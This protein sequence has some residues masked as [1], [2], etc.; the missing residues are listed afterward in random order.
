MVERRTHIVRGVVGAAVGLSVLAVVV[1]AVDA[2]KVLAA[3]AS[4]NWTWLAVA[5]LATLIHYALVGERFTAFMRLFTTDVPD[6]VLRRTGM[7][8]S[9]LGRAIGLAGIVAFSIELGAVKRFGGRVRDLVGASLVNS[10]MKVAI[11]G[12]AAVVGLAW[13]FGIPT[14]QPGA[15]TASVS[16]VHRF[17]YA[18]I[19]F[20]AVIGLLAVGGAVVYFG[21]AAW[22]RLEEAGRAQEFR[23]GAGSVVTGLQAILHRPQ[24]LAAPTMWLA[25]EILVLTTVLWFCLGALGLW[26]SPGVAFVAYAVAGFSRIVSIIPGNLGVQEAGVTAALALMGVPWAAGLAAVILARTLTTWLPALI[27]LPLGWGLLT[28][29]GPGSQAVADPAVL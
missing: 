11:R 13:V 5:A 18:L 9:A 3:L 16:T 23:E 19:G 14:I 12:T 22:H 7:V 26:V 20:A 27:C 8:S 25:A 1:H 15:L 6:A 21:R 17:E 2:S 4:A 29:G 10:S 28:D 24:R